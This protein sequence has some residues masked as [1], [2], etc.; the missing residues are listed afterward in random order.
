MSESQAQAK[1]IA[2]IDAAKEQHKMPTKEDR[3]Y[4][5][6]QSGSV[7]VQPIREYGRIYA[8]KT[9]TLIK[10]NSTQKRDSDENNLDTN[11]AAI[12]NSCDP[13]AEYSPYCAP[14]EQTPLLGAAAVVDVDGN[15]N[16]NRASNNAVQAGNPF[17]AR[18][19]AEYRF[20][21]SLAWKLGSFFGFAATLTAMFG[22][23]FSLS[24]LPNSAFAAAS[25]P[26]AVAIG[27]M[28][29]HA[30]LLLAISL[31]LGAYRAP[32][33]PHSN[34]TRLYSN[35]SSKIRIH[36]PTVLT[37]FGILGFSGGILIG[38]F[39][40]DYSLAGF[41]PFIP[42]G[43]A[44]QFMASPF[45]PD[46]FSSTG[47]VAGSAATFPRSQRRFSEP[48]LHN[49]NDAQLFQL[50]NFNN[51][52]NLQNSNSLNANYGNIL[53]HRQSGVSV[54]QFGNQMLLNQ[55][56]ES[57]SQQIAQMLRFNEQRQI[58]LNMLLSQFNTSTNHL[59]PQIQQFPSN[60]LHA[61]KHKSGNFDSNTKP[62]LPNTPQNIPHTRLHTAASALAPQTTPKL[63]RA[64]VSSIQQHQIQPGQQKVSLIPVADSSRAIPIDAVIV[65]NGGSSIQRSSI[66]AAT[67]KF[68]SALNNVIKRRGSLSSFDETL[69]FPNCRPASDSFSSPFA[70]SG[71]G[72]AA[73]CGLP[74]SR[75]LSDI[76]MATREYLDRENCISKSPLLDDLGNLTETSCGDWFADTAATDGFSNEN[77]F[78][79]LMMGM[80]N[81]NNEMIFGQNSN[82]A[83]EN[84]NF[85]L[86]HTSAADAAVRI[87]LQARSVSETGYSSSISS[88]SGD[89]SVFL[90]N[91]GFRPHSSQ[92]SFSNT[93]SSNNF[94]NFN[95]GFTSAG[96]DSPAVDLTSTQFGLLNFDG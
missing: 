25:V 23:L 6:D 57:S 2:E 85:N 78:L 10:R 40:D 53:S 43:A 88:Y 66:E 70:S 81:I 55:D 21:A 28:L 9:V 67:N 17:V 3:M 42:T 5:R 12:I 72:V 74:E 80:N 1:T 59:S 58:Q 93:S 73:G 68:K 20:G 52:S 75:S 19:E 89:A 64:S 92:S 95:I 24:Q 50:S 76:V 48:A 86:Y 41:W 61:E 87:E 83:F 36:S 26:L 71:T 69:T 79:D 56:F 22:Y 29:L 7:G 35:P 18:R 39:V 63:R 8:G 49:F 84:S 77:E 14:S 33:Y 37:F 32:N 45:I 13:L 62:P 60:L 44:N 27:T 54:H 34:P 46:E 94:N 31:R 96:I 82:A 47:F 15:E 11:T 30:L 91:G 65:N 4:H 16:I 38:V 51:N 90:Q